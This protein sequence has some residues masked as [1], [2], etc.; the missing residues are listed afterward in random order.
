M[1]AVGIAVAAFTVIGLTASL[2]LI[3]K[4]DTGQTL[5]QVGIDDYARLTEAELFA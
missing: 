4:L 3:G 1:V 5:A 2:T